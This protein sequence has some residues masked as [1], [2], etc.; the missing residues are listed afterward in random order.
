[1]TNA[2]ELSVGR[3]VVGLMCTNS[4]SVAV[5]GAPLWAFYKH[6]TTSDSAAE[7]TTLFI[8]DATLRME[9]LRVSSCGGLFLQKNMP[10][11]RLRV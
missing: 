6:A 7:A 9:P 2:V 3:G 10:P 5:S 4:V 1:M 8:T 11:R